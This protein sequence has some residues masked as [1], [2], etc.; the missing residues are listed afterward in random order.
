[1]EQSLL[2]LLNLILPPHKQV[3]FAS[4]RCSSKNKCGNVDARYTN[5][6]MWIAEYV[7]CRAHILVLCTS[8]ILGIQG[9]TCKH[10][11]LIPHL[12]M[13]MFFFSF[14]FSLN[15]NPTW[16]IGLE[17][18]Q[19][20]VVNTSIGFCCTLGNMN[21]SKMLPYLSHVASYVSLLAR[22]SID[23]CPSNIHCLSTIL[24]L[25]CYGVMCANNVS[26]IGMIIQSHYI[27]K[28]CRLSI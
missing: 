3:E 16:L 23:M 9:F 11:S 10:D 1:M 7:K 20:F 14:L 25:I 26:R 15:S 27:P 4:I 5:K 6:Y 28:M 21:T 2:A 24:Q 18:R 8:Y 12:V 17:E 19:L 13:L 22:H